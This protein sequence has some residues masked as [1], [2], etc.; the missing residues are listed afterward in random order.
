M[1]W[2]PYQ[3][4]NVH[5]DAPSGNYTTANA[6]YK[7]MNTVLGR[8]TEQVINRLD[9]LVLVQKTCTEDV[10]REPWKQLHPD[11]S[12]KTLTSAL[13]EKYD[14]FYARSY[15]VAK[16]GWKQ[17]YS[18]LHNSSGSTLYDLNNEQPLWLNQTVVQLVR[19]RATRPDICS[20]WKWLLPLL[21]S[22]AV[23]W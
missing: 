11:G 7:G 2:D 16:V 19:S 10:C 15:S 12:V 4:T 17:C 1:I 22:L 21:G 5:P 14:D 9:A 13:H 6:Y 3:M 18:G 23:V 8:P 20:R